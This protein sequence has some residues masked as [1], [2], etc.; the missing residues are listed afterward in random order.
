M[1]VYAHDRSGELVSDYEQKKAAMLK[2]QEE[3]NFNYHKKKVQYVTGP[4]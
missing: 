4:M 3:T 2:S 1:Y